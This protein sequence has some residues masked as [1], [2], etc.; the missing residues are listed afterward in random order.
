MVGQRNILDKIREFFIR[1]NFIHQKGP[2][3]SS[4]REL[5]DLIDR[6]IDNDMHYGLEWDDFISWKNES[7]LIEDFRQEIGNY[8]PLLFSKSRS[9]MLEYCNNLIEIRNSI[10]DRIAHPIRQP[11]SHL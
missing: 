8:E 6:F 4:L 9:K 2:P 1:N 10:A 3:V 5:V 11:L 7:S